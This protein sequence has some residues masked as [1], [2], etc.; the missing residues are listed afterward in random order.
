MESLK[1]SEDWQELCFVEIVDHDGWDRLNFKFSWREELIT[2]KEFEKRLT[3]STVRFNPDHLFN[4]W[5]EQ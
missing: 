4:I 2:R 5:K 3:D 1:T